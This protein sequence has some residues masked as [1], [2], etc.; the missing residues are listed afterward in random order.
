MEV[1]RV[2][3]LMFFVGSRWGWNGGGGAVGF[4]IMVMNEE[5][6]LDEWW[7][8]VVGVRNGA[9][10]RV[11]EWGIGCCGEN[12]KCCR[13]VKDPWSWQWSPYSTGELVWVRVGGTVGDVGLSG[14]VWLSMMV[15]RG[16][17]GGSGGSMVPWLQ[18]AKD[19]SGS[20]WEEPRVAACGCARD[21]GA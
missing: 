14:G 8:W 4:K 1:N 11:L 6:G 12:G 15:G 5:V 10:V 19:I 7:L 3:G 9:R 21:H 16:S 20:C 2:D 18:P 17:N 13:L